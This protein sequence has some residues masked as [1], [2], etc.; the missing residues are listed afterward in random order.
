MCYDDEVEV[1]LVTFGENGPYLLKARKV[2][3]DLNTNL[4]NSYE[5]CAL[6]FHPERGF[7][8][9]QLHVQAVFYRHGPGIRETRKLE[10]R[11][12]FLNELFVGHPWP[13]LLSRLEHNGCVVHVERGVVG[14]AVRS[15]NR[16]EYGLDFRKRA[17]D[18]GLFLQQLSSLTNGNSRQGGG[19]VQ[20][21]T[22]KQWRHKL[23]ADL[24]R[25]GNCDYQKNQ[26]DQQRRF[27][28]PQTEP[29]HGQ[30]QSL[31]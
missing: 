13:P 17:D 18:A 20:G 1:L 28:K 4:L 19:H 29:E 25:Q 3:L 14:G 27:A 5:G 30:V 12:H 15:S 6:Y 26:I 22:F 8:S 24:E 11:I 31:R 10:L 9:G 7:D 16:S 2:L 23:A 21:R